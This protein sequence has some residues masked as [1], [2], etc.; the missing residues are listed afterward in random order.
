MAVSL[1]SSSCKAE[2]GKPFK[3]LDQSV[4]SCLATLAFLNVCTAVL[5]DEVSVLVLQLSSSASASASL[6]LSFAF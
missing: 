1:R 3:R 4:L 2:A 6:F 5:S